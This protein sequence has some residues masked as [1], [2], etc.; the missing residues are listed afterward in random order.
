VPAFELSAGVGVY[1]F[2]SGQL[3][4]AANAD[5]GGSSASLRGQPTDLGVM[6]FGAGPELRFPLL[7]RLYVFGRLAPQALQVSTELNDTSGAM[8]FA[9]EQWTFALDAALGASFRF[10]AADPGG[11]P[12]PIAFFVRAEAGY[13]WSPAIDLKLP[14]T[15]DAPVRTAPLDLNE[16][17]LSG[18][19]F[20]AAIGV[21]Y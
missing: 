14:P 18:L 19:S 8:K 9:D 17:A 13:L 1:D 3:A 16:L 12:H 6:R 15:G 4:I 5:F 11:L 10:A 21:G 20:G 7:D 2:S